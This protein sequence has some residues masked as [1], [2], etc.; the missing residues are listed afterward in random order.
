[1]KTTLMTVPDMMCGHCEKTIRNALSTLQGVEVITVDLA[2]KTV[3]VTH[4]D[5]VSA[6]QLLNTVAA[7]DFHPQL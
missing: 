6:Q 5:S 2:A 4:D 3:T 1:M 7:E